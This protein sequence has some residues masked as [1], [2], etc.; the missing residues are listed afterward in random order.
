MVAGVGKQEDMRIIIQHSGEVERVKWV[1]HDI[2]CM[3]VV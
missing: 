3:Y 2:S 1:C